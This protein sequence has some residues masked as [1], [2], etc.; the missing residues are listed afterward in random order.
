MSLSDL[1]TDQMLIGGVWRDAA[2]RLPL[3]DPSTG[4]AIGEI[5]AC[6]P[7]DIDEAVAAA[8]AALDGAWGTLAAAERGR[9]LAAL[10]RKVAEHAEALA[11]LESRDVGKPLTQARADARA[12]ARYLEFYGGAADKLHGE[13]LPYL[14]GYTVFTLREPHGVTG[15]IIPWNYP[16]QIIGRSVVAALTVGNAAVLKPAEEACLTAL[17]FARL[18]Q[19]VGFPPGALNVAPGRGRRSA[20]RWRAIQASVM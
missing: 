9:L 8:Q 18:A 13:T 17:A 15:H 1:P 11:V 10:G 7:S 6:T 4:E 19:D 12:L 3:E 16:M 20:R 2:D 14:P 5:A